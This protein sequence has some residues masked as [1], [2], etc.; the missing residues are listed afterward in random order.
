MNKQTKRNAKQSI[1]LTGLWMMKR[2]TMWKREHKKERRKREI[3][4]KS[5]K[6]R[7]KWEKVC[8]MKG[9]DMYI[10]SLHCYHALF[11]ISVA[12]AFSL[13][14]CESCY[15][16]FLLSLISFYFISFWVFLRMSVHLWL[17]ERRTFKKVW[18]KNAEKKIHSFA[19]SFSLSS[20]IVIIINNILIAYHHQ[21]WSA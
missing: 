13:S 4:I 18:C 6:G 14:L 9:N 21:S 8:N 19:V 2:N 5:Q 12:I 7:N 1:M 15:I 16:C 10:L 11:L 3:K 20:P 17:I